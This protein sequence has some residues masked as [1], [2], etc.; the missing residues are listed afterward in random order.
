[1]AAIRNGRWKLH[2]ADKLEWPQRTF[3]PT[4]LYDLATDPSERVDVA[5][6]HPEIVSRLTEQARRFHAS[7]EFAE[8]PPA[9]FPPGAPDRPPGGVKTRA[10]RR[11]AQ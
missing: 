7:V 6:S 5:K 2:F 10:D 11:A 8:M 4:E 9:H 1:L 3:E